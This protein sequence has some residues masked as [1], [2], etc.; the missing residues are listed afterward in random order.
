MTDR[1]TLVIGGTG[2]I[3]RRVAERLWQRGLPVRLGTR[4]SDL[5]FDW[6]NP[7]TWR[8]ALDGVHA[9]YVSYYPDLTVP[10]TAELIREFAGI[11][12]SAG[13]RR[14]VLLSGRGEAEAQRCEQAI[15]YSDARWTIVRASWFCQNFSEGYFLEPILDGEVALPAGDVGEPFVDAEDIAAVA[16]AALTDDRHDGEVYEV[17]GPRLL[18]FAEAIA[19]IGAAAGRDVRYVRVSVDDYAAALTAASVPDDMVRLIRYLFT[20]VLDG[21]NAS[22]QD[23]VGRALNRPPRDFREF[24]RDAAASGVWHRGSRLDRRS[25]DPAA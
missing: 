23:G 10:G 7:A 15:R 6:N 21:R 22:V 1:T 2:K 24:A 14:L 19:A 20:D 11:A 5:P 4:S 8:P 17:T 16:A 9:A 13:V 25:D 18:T 12:V 3:G